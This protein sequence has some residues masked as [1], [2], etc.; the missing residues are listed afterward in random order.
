MLLV[1]LE[2]IKGTTLRAE[3]SYSLSGSEIQQIIPGQ[4]M[5]GHVSNYNQTFKIYEIYINQEDLDPLGSDLYVELTPCSGKLSFY[6]SDTYL[7]L[8]KPTTYQ[9]LLDVVPTSQST[10]GLQIS[11][12]RDIKAYD[13]IYVGI[14]SS[15]EF[16]SG[17]LG[18]QL[19]SFFEIRTTLIKSTQPDLSQTY[20]FGANSNKEI[21]LVNDDH[22]LDTFYIK[23]N[24]I[25]QRGN[26]D[27]EAQYKP[28][29]QVT[30]QLFAGANHDSRYSLGSLCSIEHAPANTLYSLFVDEEAQ[31]N[32]SLKLKRSDLRNV[33]VIGMIARVRDPI[34]GDMI[35]LAYEP[36]TFNIKLFGVKLQTS[37]IIMLVALS[38]L[39]LFCMGFIVYCLRRKNIKLQQRLDHETRYVQQEFDATNISTS[40]QETR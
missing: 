36:L 34:S 5:R 16:F 27:T 38:M 23:W 26:S 17:D 21:D 31:N 12:V 15:N 39:L 1:R 19:D 7:S 8:F 14:E 10:F 3:V 30:Y 35:A 11:R 24:Q 40:M 22:D 20:F 33:Q 32:R 2:V 18:K 28:V 6:V 13:V 25:Y 9:G 4:S 37:Q 29:E